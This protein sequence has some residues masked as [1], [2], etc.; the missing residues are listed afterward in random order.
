MLLKQVPPCTGNTEFPALTT[1]PITMHVCARG[2][3]RAHTHRMGQER[4][5][6]NLTGSH[7]QPGDCHMSGERSKAIAKSTRSHFFKVQHWEEAEHWGKLVCLWSPLEQKQND[8]LKWKVIDNGWKGDSFFEFFLFGGRG[9]RGL[10]IKINSQN[11]A[12]YLWNGNT[13][14]RGIRTGGAER[15]EYRGNAVSLLGKGNSLFWTRESVFFLSRETDAESTQS[16]TLWLEC[17]FQMT[18]F[19]YCL[20][21][22]S[23]LYFTHWEWWAHPVGAFWC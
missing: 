9:W 14:M 13:K 6:I 11:I 21:A 3:A 16:L 7:A 19:H 15:K 12:Q 20:P 8:I 4:V 17:P 5:R 22:S 10:K 23:V 2:G 18:K 1:T